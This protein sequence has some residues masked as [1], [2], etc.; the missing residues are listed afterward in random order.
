M[1]KYLILL[2]LV[3]VINL[4]CQN[5]FKECLNGSWKLSEKHKCNT[6]LNFSNYIKFTHDEVHFYNSKDEKNEIIYQIKNL[7]SPNNHINSQLIKFENGEVWQLN[8][9]KINNEIRL[10]WKLDIDAEG[11]HWI[12]ADDRG[13]IRDKEKRRLAL[14]SEINT[15]YFKEE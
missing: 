2:T 1:K 4:Y 12:H 6:L 13:I 9:R 11:I 5:S 7:D 8:I 14:E 3:N 10:I 15:Y